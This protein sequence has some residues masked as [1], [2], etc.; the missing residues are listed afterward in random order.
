MKSFVRGGM[1]IFLL[2]L[3]FGAGYWTRGIEMVSAQTAGFPLLS[4]AAAYVEA[5]FVKEKPDPSVLEY[6]L[7][8][9]YLAELRDPNTFFI[10]PAVAASES[11]SLAGRYGGIGVDLQRNEDGFFVLYPFEESPALRGG[12]RDGD[13]II[14][15]NGQALDLSSPM[16]EVRQAL[17][18]ELTEGA[19]VT[20]V[21]RNIADEEAAERE[22]FIP[23]EEILVPS[24]TWRVLFEAP[25]T[26]YINI[27]RFTSR[28]PEEFR[29]AVSELRDQGIESVVLDV[30]NNP[31]GLKYESVLIAGEFFDGGVLS[32]EE[33]VEG[34]SETPDD[35]GGVLV[36]LPLV[37]LV[38]QGTASAAE[39]VAGA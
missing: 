29:Q 39:I 10:E 20:L 14:S 28:T 25:E 19:G 11:D 1:L 7:I 37:V 13:I 35:S 16:D 23:F 17:R 4:E 8:R 18:G 5:N 6:A 33:R 3:A 9:A 22:Y 31:G 26:G 34:E 36:D 30:R 2:L 21:V 27:S 38:N 15:I 12:I 32:I 24:V